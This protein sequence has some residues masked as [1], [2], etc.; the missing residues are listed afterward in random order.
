[1]RPENLQKFAGRPAAIA[2]QQKRFSFFFFAL[3]AAFLG[4]AGCKK[5]DT[6]NN[7]NNYKPRTRVYYIAAVEQEWNYVPTGNNVFTG[8]PFNHMDSMFAVRI[9]TPDTQRIGPKYIKAR[10][11]EYTDASFT[12]P[13]PVTPEWE[14]LG[15]LGPVI[16]GV[17]GDSI[18]VYFKN[19]TSIKAS[20]HVHGLFYDK[21]SEGSGNASADPNTVV[22]PGGSLT[23]RFFAREGSGPGPNQSSSAVWVYH[24]GVNNNQS[25]MYAGMVGAIVVTKA[26]MANENAKPTDVD[27]EFVTLYNIFNENQSNLLPKNINTYLPGFTNPA[28]M[29]FDTSNMKHSINGFI[30][31]NLPGLVMNKGERVRWYV[32]GLGGQMDFHSAH[33]HGN[34]ATFDQRNVDVVELMPATSLVADMKP[35]DPGT[36]A[37]HCHVADHAGAGM[38]AFYTVRP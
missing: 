2:F 19:N 20:I 9:F 27:R 30:M 28:P 31:A 26:G 23:Y 3:I 36:W 10:Y 1:M 7:N 13:K 15:I 17:V 4:L 34:V 35:D 29:D 11:V 21:A 24:S 5:D 18:L 25:D 6:N 37:Y 38:D 32:I 14:H 16:R 8:K 33:W 22:S 12:T